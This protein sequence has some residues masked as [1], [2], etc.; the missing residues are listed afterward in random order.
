M[1]VPIGRLLAVALLCSALLLDVGHAADASSERDGVLRLASCSAQDLATTLAAQASMQQ[2]KVHKIAAQ[3]KKA[4]KSGKTSRTRSLKKKLA[5]QKKVLVGAQQAATT[6]AASAAATCRPPPGPPAE[7]PHPAEQVWSG[8]DRCRDVL[9]IGVRGSGQKSDTTTWGLGPEVHEAWTRL[10][11]VMDDS[12]DAGFASIEYTALTTNG[13]PG[14]LDS[15]MTSV[16][17]GVTTASGFFRGRYGKCPRERYV[18]AGFSQGSMV[19]H[20]AIWD[21]LDDPLKDQAAWDRIDGFLLIADGDRI[22]NDA[23]AD[24]IDYGNAGEGLGVGHQAADF[25]LLIGPKVHNAQ[26]RM[27][28]GFLE[29]RFHSVCLPNDPICILENPL[30]LTNPAKTAIHNGYR[31]DGIQPYASQG[32]VWVQQAVEA[33]GGRMGPD[34]VISSS[35][36]PDAQI[37]VH[38]DE[39]LTTADN[40]NGTWSV[41][42]GSLPPGIAL[43]TDGHLAGVPAGEPDTYELTVAF[44]DTIGKRTTR[45]LSLRTVSATDPGHLV[46]NVSV[47]TAGVPANGHS[48]HP[49]VS[50]D[51]QVVAFE[52]VADNLVPGDTNG[53]ND[54]FVR[55]LRAGTTARVSVSG[56]GLQ[57][58]GGSSRPGI[59]PNGRYVAFWSLARNLTA[60]DQD[61]AFDLYLHDRVTGTTQ[62]VSVTSAGLSFG[63]GPQGIPLP[64]RPAVDDD[65]RFV[66]FTRP[67]TTPL[68]GGG[69]DITT[70]VYVRDL[71]LSTTRAVSDVP[72]GDH[73]IF[74]GSGP[75]ISA[76]G[77]IV[78]F[79]GMVPWG[80]GTCPGCLDD[81]EVYQYDTVTGAS[82][83][84]AEGSSPVLAR[85]GGLVAYRSG[86]D[87]VVHS[88]ATGGDVGRLTLPGAGLGQITSDGR[89]LAHDV[90]S[91]DGTLFDLFRHDTTTGRSVSVIGGASTAVDCCGGGWMGYA[92]SEDGRYVTIA[93]DRASTGDARGLSAVYRHDLAG[94]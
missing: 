76:D 19:V 73:P 79:G 17:D 85:S 15:F 52:S 26:D 21:F 58:D 82:T 87:R 8:N 6:A 22:G 68:P 1:R 48:G 65:G 25:G 89:Y 13:L 72:G 56:A 57:A 92:I 60:S 63:S 77:A 91:S 62:R 33:I 80:G 30:D 69:T 32:V 43:S 61:N 55:D 46:E 42:A 18:F 81:T 75:S 45:A 47:S 49:S 12:I 24:G 51:G 93:S 3:L 70:H 86:A 84:L 88:I 36:L 7:P 4:R 50:A 2:V 16:D 14:T 37:G 71:T 78:V 83:W 34:P 35:A 28:P 94:R 67:V 11:A 38:Y 23:D 90:W 31:S 53:S 74:G 9:L 10:A 40:R 59:S 27:I 54:I 20:R 44:V 5:A 29:D 66:A 39:R 64:D 41:E